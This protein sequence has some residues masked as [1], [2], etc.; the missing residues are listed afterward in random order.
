MSKL[1]LNYKCSDAYNYFNIYISNATFTKDTLPAVLASNVTTLYYDIQDPTYNPIYV[2][3]SS[4][5]NGIE[6]FS[7]VQKFYLNRD[8][9]P[10]KN[11]TTAPVAFYKLNDLTGNY[12]DYSGNNRHATPHGTEIRGAD[13]IDVTGQKSAA[14]TVGSTNSICSYTASD[15]TFG[16]STT[17]MMWIEVPDATN[18]LYGEFFKIGSGGKGY[19]IGFNNGTNSA[20]YS[21]VAGRYILI[22]QNAISFRPTT[23]R[24]SDAAQKIHLAVTFV[25]GTLKVY[26]NG[27]LSFTQS[28]VGNPNTFTDTWIIGMGEINCGYPIKMSRVAIYNAEVSVTDI[29]KCYNISSI[30]TT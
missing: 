26:V 17:V 6:K 23:I 29:Y 11:L 1:R 15:L 5:H 20:A 28:G 9:E 10:E 19:S 3:V 18:L 27:V 13:S 4:V 25:S 21:N 30:Q 7:L 24:I 12:L 8:F 16:T 14:V 2:M 22:G